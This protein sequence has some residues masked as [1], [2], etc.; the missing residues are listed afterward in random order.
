M[1]RDGVCLWGTVPGVLFAVALALC[2]ISWLLAGFPF[3]VPWVGGV[4]VFLFAG[5]GL[6]QR[7]YSPICLSA[8]G[9]LFPPPAC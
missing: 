1:P 3:L 5:I 7:Y 2:P 8:A 4:P 6:S 9:W